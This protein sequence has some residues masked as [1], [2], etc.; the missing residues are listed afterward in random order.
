MQ[1][2]YYLVQQK[3][4]ECK[5]MTYSYKTKKL[6]FTGNINR[7]IEFLLLINKE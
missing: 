2:D 1:L 3:A 7:L 6:E 5:L 4:L